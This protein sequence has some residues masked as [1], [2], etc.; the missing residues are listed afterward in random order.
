MALETAVIQNMLIEN[1]GLSVTEFY[2]QHDIFTFEVAPDALHEVIA[3]L[4][5]NETLRFNFLTDVCGI[6]Y[7]D[8]TEDRQLAVVYH[9]HNWLDNVRI[10]IKTYLSIKNPVVNTVSDLFLSANWQERETYDFY[11]IIFKNHPQLKRILNMDEMVSFPL[12][13]EFPLEDGGRTD[14]D[15]RFFG[16]TVHNC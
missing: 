16:R 7:P 9:M 11:G 10:R 13:K 4:K 2:Q 12:R 8:Y 15:D 1:F 14:K 6:H 5:D 3:F